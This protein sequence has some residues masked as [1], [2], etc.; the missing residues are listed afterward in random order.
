MP[1]PTGQTP[2]VRY[3]EPNTNKVREGSAAPL[4]VANRRSR[5]HFHADRTAVETFVAR[6]IFAHKW[7]E[8]LFLKAQWNEV[9]AVAALMPFISLST[10]PIN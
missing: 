8:G 3:L 1:H 6:P 2:A 10:H 5:S 7:N 9:R 4:P